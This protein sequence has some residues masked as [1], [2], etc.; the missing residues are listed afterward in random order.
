MKT[1]EVSVF[2]LLSLSNI[3]IHDVKHLSLTNMQEKNPKTINKEK[4][5]Y[6]T[7]NTT[8]VKM[9]H[10]GMI[11]TLS[12]PGRL[13]CTLCFMQYLHIERKILREMVS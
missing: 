3:K 13:K 11:G 1:F 6:C 8:G 4:H 10:S 9:F 5:F 7:L 12:G 2:P